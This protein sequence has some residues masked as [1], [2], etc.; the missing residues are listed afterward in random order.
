M[1]IRNLPFALECKISKVMNKE[2]KFLPYRPGLKTGVGNHI[3]WYEIGSGFGEPGVPPPPPRIP[4][5]TP[6]GFPRLLTFCC[7]RYSVPSLR[8]KVIQHLTII[9]SFYLE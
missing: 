9:I 3:V 8:T 1:P 7:S 4:E 5:S 2:H 6:S